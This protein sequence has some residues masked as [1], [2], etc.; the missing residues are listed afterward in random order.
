[1][2]L[3]YLFNS[4]NFYSIKHREKEKSKRLDRGAKKRSNLK[5]KSK[6][7]EGRLKNEKKLH[8]VFCV[9]N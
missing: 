1:M 2:K 8:R 4:S 5:L 9:F 3:E 7:K 6:Y